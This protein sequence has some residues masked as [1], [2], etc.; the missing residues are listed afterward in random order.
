MVSSS[1][2]LRQRCFNT[3]TCSTS[4]AWE[5]LV[6]RPTLTA[7]PAGLMLPESQD[8]SSEWTPFFPPVRECVIGREQRGYLFFLPFLLEPSAKLKSLGDL[9]R[10]WTSVLDAWFWCT[11]RMLLM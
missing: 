5:S 6:K 11:A 1:D 4:S 7:V 2:V 8:Y 3:T 9:G 10:G